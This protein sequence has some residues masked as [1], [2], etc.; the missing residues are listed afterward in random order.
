MSDLKRSLCVWRAVIAALACVA[1]VS[2]AAAQENSLQSAVVSQQS[3]SPAAVVTAEATSSAQTPQIAAPRP[4]TPAPVGLGGQ[5]AP[6]L[7]VRG[8]FRGRLEGF[9]G[10][11]YKPDNSDAYMLDR[12]RI[13]A[14]V[15]PSSVAKFVVQI[16][17]ARVF[18]KTTGQMAV[19]FRDTIDVRMAYGE[20][21]GA[22][23][24]VRA[25]RQE[26]VFGE[27][28]LIGH[29]NWVNDAC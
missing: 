8:E 19:P 12:F 18:D 23:N 28:R 25:G 3:Q 14:T 24:M 22:R 11:S 7:Q 20:F 10:G 26:L 4:A 21:G 27:Q 16:Q 29:L 9:S 5:F 1:G 6:W 13:N 15:A 17:D 2:T